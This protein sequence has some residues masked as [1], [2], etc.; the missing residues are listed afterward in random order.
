MASRIWL[1][2]SEKKHRRF[3]M[4]SSC[5]I[6]WVGHLFFILSFCFHS[7]GWLSS[8]LTFFQHSNFCQL[9]WKYWIITKILTVKSYVTRGRRQA[10]V[11]YLYYW[12]FLI[13]IFDKDILKRNLK[14]HFKRFF[15]ILWI[16]TSLIQNMKY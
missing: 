10:C 12:M 9:Q 5:P 15:S 3:L 6:L 8:F 2:R 11:N 13:K 16:L 14:I 4:G 7:P 1:K